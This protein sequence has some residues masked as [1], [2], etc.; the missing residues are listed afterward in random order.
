[1]CV[2]WILGWG[3]AV[4]NLMSKLETGGRNHYLNTAKVRVE[5]NLDL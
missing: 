4:R 3:G 2:R 5:E 1:M